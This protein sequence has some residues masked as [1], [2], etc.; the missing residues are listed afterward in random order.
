VYPSFRRREPT[1]S[2]SDKRHAFIE[3]VTG[4]LDCH[5]AAISRSPGPECESELANF[6]THRDRQGRS[7]PR[8]GIPAFV[9]VA[10]T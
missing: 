2:P 7:I 9:N 4:R 10:L 5:V 3:F 1:D 8:S 6:L